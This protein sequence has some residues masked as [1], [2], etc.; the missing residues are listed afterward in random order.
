MSNFLRLIGGAAKEVTKRKDENRK[1]ENDMMLTN[2]KLTAA[3]QIKNAS[4]VEKTIITAPDGKQI[5]LETQ[6]DRSKQ[7]LA[8]ANEITSQ[9]AFKLDEAGY[10]PNID[11]PWLQNDPTINYVGK[12]I[13]QEAMGKRVTSDKGL[14]TTEF[15][16]G[17][18]LPDGDNRFSSYKA[19]IEGSYLSGDNNIDPT[20][21]KG[22]RPGPD[23]AG[24]TLDG[25]EAPFTSE[26]TPEYIESGI[27]LEDITKSFKESGAVLNTPNTKRFSDAFFNV[28][29]EEGK[30][31]S[32]DYTGDIP[33]FISI[34]SSAFSTEWVKS[35]TSQ[36]KN[37]KYSE[38]TA[39][40][41]NAV[42]ANSLANKNVDAAADEIEKI[43]YGYVDSKSVTHTG[44]G[45]TGKVVDI[46]LILNAFSDPVEGVGPQLKNIWSSITT[47]NNETLAIT[48]NSTQRMDN[49]EYFLKLKA[50]ELGLTVEEALKS[51]E[52][53]FTDKKYTY[54]GVALNITTAL[55]DQ[56]KR[57]GELN[58]NG[59]V[60]TQ[61][62]RL[63]AIQIGLAFQM[64]I[65]LQGYQGG[66][67]VSD[68]DFDRAWQAITG[69]KRGSFW[70]QF[71]TTSA[72]RA[73]LGAAREQI[74]TN[75][76][77]N[78]GYM[79]APRGTREDSQSLFY[80]MFKQ[81]AKEQSLSVAQLGVDTLFKNKNFIITY[82]AAAEGFVFDSSIEDQIINATAL[83]GGGN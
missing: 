59:D 74:V 30:L 51:D 41:L 8:F 11:L 22:Y 15:T 28:E 13:A 82:K 75:E 79:H 48:K 72:D 24:T 17:S 1:F 18:F 67:A 16:A 77:N 53:K 58:S 27:R 39:Q 6:S 80:A 64:A 21:A 61:A 2:A 7:P 83:G 20:I 46:G 29:G 9:L 57:V 44:I 65:A 47:T 60:I 4:S 45:A 73:T 42:K 12:V 32:L 23:Y 66:K 70:G 19:E 78:E 71:T 5:V 76:I 50:E 49:G 31:F 34:V 33:E 37:S 26:A 35:K 54:K 10:D 56:D 55:A 68:A 14:I 52:F 63:Q 25:E 38:E 81:R 43:I 40:R 3:E 36:S 69:S 62:Y